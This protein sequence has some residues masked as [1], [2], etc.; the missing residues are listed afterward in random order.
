MNDPLNE[1]EKPLDPAAAGIVAK[2]RW[3]MLISG[4]TTLVAIAAVVGVIGYR[5]F[6]A[7]GSA[8][9]SAARAD[10][11]ALLP[12]GARVVAIT[13]AEDR[14]VVTIE[15]AGALEARTFDLKTLAP[16]GRLRFVTEP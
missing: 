13:A 3:L 4:V 2:V 12:K 14:I 10:V 5:V 16:A 7:E 11:A 6:R 8:A 15:L 1:D 9:P